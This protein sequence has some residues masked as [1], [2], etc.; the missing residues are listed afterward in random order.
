MVKWGI[1][2]STA[3]VFG[4]IGLMIG[5]LI[6]AVIG[7]LVGPPVVLLILKVIKKRKNDTT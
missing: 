3:I 1:V 4:I 2:F 6:G 7:F 5:G